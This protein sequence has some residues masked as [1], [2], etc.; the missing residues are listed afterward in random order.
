[1]KAIK[2]LKSS[3][4]FKKSLYLGTN[5]IYEPIQIHK[6]NKGTEGEIFYKMGILFSFIIYI[7]ILFYFVEKFKDLFIGILYKNI[8]IVKGSNGKLYIEHCVEYVF[9]S[10]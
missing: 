6:Y 8:N 10:T 1:M 9:S 4:L 2:T 5:I 3:H 7:F